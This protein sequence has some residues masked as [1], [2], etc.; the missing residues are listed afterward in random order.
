MRRLLLIARRVYM[1]YVRTVGFWLSLFALPLVAVGSG[2]F[3]ASMENGGEARE[4][5]VL[6]LSGADVSADFTGRL[7]R[8]NRVHTVAVPAELAPQTEVAGADDVARTLVAEDGG[9]SE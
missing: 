9:T 8:P 7:N 6:D 4:I 5:A 1:A 3:I 2:F